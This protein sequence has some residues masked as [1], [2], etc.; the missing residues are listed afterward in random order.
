M[1]TPPYLLRLE[2]VHEFHKT[3]GVPVIRAFDDASCKVALLRRELHREEF[4]EYNSATSAIDTLD[5]LVD[6]DYIACGS[7]LSLGIEPRGFKP[8]AC[9]ATYTGRLLDELNKTQLCQ[10]GLT[11]ELNLLRA[12]I[13]QTAEADYVRFHDAFMCVHENNMAK[14]WTPAQVAN[15]D[16][17][18]HKLV[19]HD[20]RYIV[21]RSDGKVL[22]PPGHIKPD[23]T[24]YV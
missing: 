23:L 5:A 4:A 17:S 22:K 12:I 24:P 3:F 11:R 18:I 6:M 16:L 7:L 9:I 13:E 2:A 20:D 1:K 10:K 14:M 15:L 19:L 21:Y 8:A